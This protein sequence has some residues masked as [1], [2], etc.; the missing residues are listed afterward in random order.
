MPGTT[1]SPLA[2]A[3]ELVFHGFNRIENASRCILDYR[4][5]NIFRDLWVCGLE[6]EQSTINEVPV[7]WTN[8]AQQILIIGDEP[9]DGV[10]DTSLP[11][12]AGINFR[13]HFTATSW[14]AAW[15]VRFPDVKVSIAVIDPRESC[16][17]QG[18]AS[19]LQTILGARNAAGQSLVPGAAVLNAPTLATICEWLCSAKSETR[20]IFKDAPHLRDIL[21]TTI[22]NQ[23]TSNREQHHALSNVLGAFLLRA[24]VGGANLEPV[25]NKI[26][27]YLNVLLQ[28]CGTASKPEGANSTGWITER[29]RNQFNGALLIDDMADL[30]AGFLGSAFEGDTPNTLRTTAPGEFVNAIKGGKLPLGDD[31][32]TGLPKRLDDFLSSGRQQLSSADLIPQNVSAQADEGMLRP[33]ENFVLF[34]DLRLGLGEEFQSQLRCVGL[35]LLSTKTRSLPWLTDASRTE[36]EAELMGGD[37]DETLLP[38]LIALIDPTLP[39]VI[40][41]STHRT[42]LIGPFRDYGNI[43]TTFRKPILSG[44]TRD[45]S[46]VA[47]E[48]HADFVSAVEHAGRILQVRRTFQ[49]FCENAL[50]SPGRQLPSSNHGWLI[51]IFFDESEE[52]TQRQPPRAVCA[53]GLVV[54]RSLSERG[55]PK[56]SDAAIFHGLSRE[57]CL[58]GWCADTPRQFIRPMNSAQQRRFMKKGADLDFAPNRQGLSLLG[59]M[60]TSIQS[61]LGDDGVVFPFAAISKRQQDHPE[62]LEVPRGIQWHTLERI[63]DAT[64]RKLV[65]HVL[66]GLLLRSAVI[67]SALENPKSRVAIDLGIRDY[68]CQPNATLSETFGIEIRRN[69]RPSFHSEDGYQITAETVSRTGI[70]WPYKSGIQ[71]AR[72][73]ALKDF[74]NNP[75]CPQHEV[76][77]KQL[78]YFADAVAHVTLDDWD[79]INS[80]GGEVAKFFNSGWIVDFRKDREESV[81][82]EIGR[83]W[84]Q[85]DRVAALRWAAAEL[86]NAAPPNE[87]GIDVFCE[88]YRGAT[89]LSGEEL[90]QLFANI[91]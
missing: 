80:A 86:K 4:D 55:L 88:I 48:L 60:I 65:Q 91:C 43:I 87:L 18:A 50:K 29:L 38:R 12:L 31:S 69:W 79:A 40:F 70:P 36:F 37:T 85:G 64:L 54:V 19:A 72:A 1:F 68:P 20:T 22:W 51:E 30:W 21:K 27:E 6:E 74:V 13:S 61:A 17:A 2:R 67:R 46:E 7:D 81:R 73:V 63:L 76:L 66:E 78:H 24:E 5:K 23:L 10:F 32:L 41:S 53:G 71:R 89:G 82:L 33:W 75:N 14:L 83:A 62:W 58:W 44:L 49:G 84:D 25:T 52:P 34:L 35:H 45:W 28:V 11:G 39:I 77:P 59:E 3:A 42:E 57:G 56:V 15:K 16:H 26:Q 9:P 8:S 47:K 90:K